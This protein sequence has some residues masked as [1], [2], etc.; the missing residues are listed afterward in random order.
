MSGTAFTLYDV[1][2]ELVAG[3]PRSETDRTAMLAS[4][5]EAERASVL[6]NMATNMGCDHPQLDNDGKCVG[7]SRQIEHRS[8][9]SRYGVNDYRG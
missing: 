7:C 5:E 4:I 2:R 9:R 1:L 8:Y 3:G 6:G